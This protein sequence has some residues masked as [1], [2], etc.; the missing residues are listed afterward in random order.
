MP[1]ASGRGQQRTPV[2]AQRG[3]DG[4]LPEQPQ[5]VGEVSGHR[6]E[7]PVRPGTEHAGTEQPAQPHDLRPERDRV[8]LV[9][10][11]LEAEL[12]AG[13]ALGALD[14]DRQDLAV[15]AGQPTL[16][17]AD[18]EDALVPPQHL[19]SPP[20]I[21]PGVVRPGSLARRRRGSA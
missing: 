8:G 18:G 21:G 7:Q 15:A 17:A 9:A 11:Q 6:D 20:V 3:P 16:A 1:G 5:H 12:L 4:A 14:E 13:H 10:V 2:L 19:E